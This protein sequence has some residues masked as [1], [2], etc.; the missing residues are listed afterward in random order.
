MGGG[1]RERPGRTAAGST[2]SRTRTEEKELLLSLRLQMAR[3]DFMFCL[4][5]NIL[6]CSCNGVF[7]SK[8]IFRLNFPLI[9]LPQEPDDQLQEIKLTS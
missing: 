4:I 5:R 7:T 9:R 3:L 6:L 2:L 1:E 8:V